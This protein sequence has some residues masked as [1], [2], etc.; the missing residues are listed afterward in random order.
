MFFLCFKRC[1]VHI[2]FAYMRLLGH[3]K[4]YIDLSRLVIQ[5]M[6]KTLIHKK[7]HPR[8]V[9]AQHF[10]DSHTALHEHDEYEVRENH[11]RMSLINVECCLC[12]VLFS[13]DDCLKSRKSY[14]CHCLLTSVALNPQSLQ[15][16][17]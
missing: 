15:A 12:P 3:I 11:F 7:F 5:I 6:G 8:F 9:I 1:T 14:V 2:V 10:S 17:Q 4:R 13:E 16:T